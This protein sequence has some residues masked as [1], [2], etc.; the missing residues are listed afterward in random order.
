MLQSC[1]IAQAL[2]ADFQ[3]FC[4]VS[5][6]TGICGRHDRTGTGFFSEAMGL[7]PVIIIPPALYLLA[8]LIGRKVKDLILLRFFPLLHTQN[9]QL[10]I[11]PVFFFNI[12][13]N[14][15]PFPQT[16][17]TRRTT[18]RSVGTFRA[19]NFLFSSVQCCFC[20]YEQPH[21][22]LPPQ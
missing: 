5:I 10:H 1:A 19:E 6:E 14:A 20:R 17:F 21:L 13:S 18:G 8:T 16:A 4:P 9:C 3:R 2:I 11:T 15:K 22:F 7:S 12:Y